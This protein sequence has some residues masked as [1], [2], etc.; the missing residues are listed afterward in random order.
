[1]AH[2]Q[3]G[4]EPPP[5][6]RTRPGRPGSYVRGRLLPGVQSAYA[7]YIAWRGWLQEGDAPPALRD[8]VGGKFTVVQVPRSHI[9]VYPVPGPGGELEPG[10]RRLNW[11]R[12]RCLACGYRSRLS[13][14]RMRRVYDR[15][16]SRGTGLPFAKK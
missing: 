12:A 1:M 8:A 5:H 3:L 14:L 15:L 4:E 2:P 6:T 13:R 11:V 9:L 16:G 7:G 10:Q